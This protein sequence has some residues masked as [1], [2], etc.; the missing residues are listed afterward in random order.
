MKDGEHAAD[1][2]DI[3]T[4]KTKKEHKARAKDIAKTDLSFYEKLRDHI[5]K[6]EEPDENRISTKTRHI[7][8]TSSSSES[9]DSSGGGEDGDSGIVDGISLL[10][11]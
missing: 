5:T 9:E 10:A 2:P 7:Y 6:K 8:F 3:T 1:E 11:D 4:N